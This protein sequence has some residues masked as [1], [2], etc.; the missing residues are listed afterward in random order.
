MTN[1]LPSLRFRLEQERKRL[2]VPWYILEQDYVASWVLAGISHELGEYVA[3]KGGTALK[4]CYFGEYRFSED[5]DFSAIGQCPRKSDL[6]VLLKSA[7]QCAEQLMIKHV[8]NSRFYLTR[9]LEKQPHPKG[10]E[11]FV[12]RVKLPWHHDPLVKI[13]IEITMAEHVLLPTVIKP[14][15]HNYGEEITQTINVY[16]LEEIIVE[17]LQAILQHTTKLHEQSWTRSRAR[18]YYDLYSIFQTFSQGIDFECVKKTLLQKCALKGITFKGVEDFFETIMLD[19]TSK[20]WQ[21]WLVPLVKTLP[22][23]EITIDALRQTVA[24]L[25][26]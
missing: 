14:I 25:L 17:K 16:S 3:F 22:S 20:T 4:K 18:D 19:E 7:C 6:E 11:A 21:Q 26:S 10:Q 2:G 24:E 13:M 15:M 23:H 5:L 9:Y 8:P 1:E 12:I